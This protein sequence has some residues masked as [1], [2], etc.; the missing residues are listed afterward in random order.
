MQG[1]LDDP[2]GTAEAVGPDGRLDTGDI[3]AVSG[4]EFCVVGLDRNWAYGP[5]CRAA[6]P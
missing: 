2:K 3:G 5:A 4:V 6:R 1:Y